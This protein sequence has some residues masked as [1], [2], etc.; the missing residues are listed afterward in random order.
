MK[1]PQ[2]LAFATA[3]VVLS[4]AAMEANF[5]KPALAATITYDFTVDVTSGSLAGIQGSGFFSYD[6][7]TLKGIGLETLRANGGL[8]ISFEFSGK[9]YN[10]TDDINFP[11]F[12][13]VQFQDS[14]LLGLSFLAEEP[15]FAFQIGTPNPAPDVFGGDEFIYGVRPDIDGEGV[16]SYSSRPV[17]EPSTLSGL[18]VIGLGLLLRK[19]L[20]S[21]ASL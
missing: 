16:V 17:P 14:S 8:D 2:K 11:N 15:G 19:K 21:S 5:M 13:M 7:S 6:D 3:G 12:P 9:T 18:A 4:C 20:S 10:E 1:L